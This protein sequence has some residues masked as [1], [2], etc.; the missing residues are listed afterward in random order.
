MYAVIALFDEQ[1]EQRIKDVWKDLHEKEI[2]FYAAEVKNR[3][4]HITIASYSN[5]NYEEWMHSMETVYKEQES[6][7]ITMQT[8]GTFLKSRTLFF[9]PTVTNELMQ[10]HTN[11]HQ[12]FSTFNDNP[13][14]IYLP[15]NWIPHCTI[16]N[17]L[18]EEKLSEAYS[19][20]SKNINP[21]Q[22]EICEIAL[23]E[24]IYDENGKCT[25]A[26]VLYS[27]KLHGNK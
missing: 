23:I 11:Y 18:S 6:I 9:A 24:L 2:S 27:K 3:L 8:I 1:M 7:T 12:Q 16:A 20:C 15:G 14:S 13:N 19:Y 4:P 25:E 10:M 22:G 17:R 5:L 26:P 21:I